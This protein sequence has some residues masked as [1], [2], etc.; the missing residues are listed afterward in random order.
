MSNTSGRATE[1]RVIFVDENG[2]EY[3]FFWNGSG[4]QIGFTKQPPTPQ[5][6]V[7]MCYGA[8]NYNVEETWK[9]VYDRKPIPTMQQLQQEAFEFIEK[10]KS[11]RIDE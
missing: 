1:I 3:A 4:K 2:I 11:N 10:Q 5:Q 6:L 8:G 7:D 9:S